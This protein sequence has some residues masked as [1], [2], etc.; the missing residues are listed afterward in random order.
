VADWYSAACEWLSEAGINQYE[1]SNFARDGGQSRHNRKYWQRDPYL[2]FGMDAHSMLR[3]GSCGVRWAN[4]DEMPTYLNGVTPRIERVGV[5]QAFE[6]AAFLGLRLV[7]GV[8][9][10]ALRAEFGD[11][12]VDGMMDGLRDAEAA[13]LLI[14]D[15]DRLRLTARGRMVSNEVFERLLCTRV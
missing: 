13:G 8:S 1:I 10:A 11:V 12:L 3:D 2:G 7:E 9:F 5:E 6:E 4:A 15:G 14:F